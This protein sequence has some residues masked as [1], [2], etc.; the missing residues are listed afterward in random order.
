MNPLEWLKAIYGPIGAP[1][2]RASL[3]C[4]MVVGALIFGVVWIM[5]ADQYHK[6]LKPPTPPAVSNTG[7]A[8][9]SG[10]NSPAVTGGQNNI[11]YGQPSSPDKKP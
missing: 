5:A 8:T 4:V 2:P 7:S 3:V 10:G 1:H 11:Q 9:T 6:S